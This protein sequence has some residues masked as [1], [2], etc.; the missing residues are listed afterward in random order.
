M[1]E[2]N[3]S[4][5]AAFRQLMMPD[6]ERIRMAVNDMVGDA[7]PGEIEGLLCDHDVYVGKNECTDNTVE[8]GLNLIERLFDKTGDLGRVFRAVADQRAQELFELENDDRNPVHTIFERSFIPKRFASLP[9][10]VQFGAMRTL[11][12]PA[13]KVADDDVSYLI[14]DMLEALPL[15]SG[16]RLDHMRGLLV[17]EASENGTQMD[18]LAAGIDIL[19]ELVIGVSPQG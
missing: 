6:D 16:S 10:V 2:I 7:T 9:A 19:A 15:D 17:S 5:K 8:I 4:L 18:R 12:E 1:P 11:F 13:L 14:S 3:P